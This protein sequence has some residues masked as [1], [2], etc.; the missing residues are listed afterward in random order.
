MEW[1]VKVY[2]YIYAIFLKITRDSAARSPVR[3]KPQRFLRNSSRLHESR[4]CF[5]SHTRKKGKKK[6]ERRGSGKSFWRRMTIIN[7]YAFHTLH[8]SAYTFQLARLWRN[9]A[10]AIR[11]GC[12]FHKLVIWT[13]H[14]RATRA[15]NQHE[16][17]L[18]V[19]SDTTRHIVK[20]PT[21]WGKRERA[22]DLF[23][24]ATSA[25][26]FFCVRN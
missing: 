19:G 4:R 15:Q 13:N 25:P 7:K 9:A 20:P 24:T 18:S 17:P 2:I 21:G 12:W 16:N 22:A 1:G 10:Y 8:R 5:R 14:T 11:Y 6:R 26:F 23:D 3:C